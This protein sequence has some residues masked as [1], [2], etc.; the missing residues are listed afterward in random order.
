MTSISGV[1]VSREEVTDL[2]IGIEWNQAIDEWQRI[3][4]W[5]NAISLTTE[6][7]DRH[8]IWG[9]MRR[10]LL[11]TDGTV[12][13]YGSNPRGDGINVYMLDF[14]GGQNEPAIG[15]VVTGAASGDVAT[16][17][18]YEV[19]SGTWGG[20]DATGILYLRSPDAIPVYQDN[21]QLNNTT[22][23]NILANGGAGL[24]A[25]GV[26]Y[27]GPQGYRMMVEIPKFYIKTM[28]PAA[29]IYRWW[30]SPV[31]KPGFVVH[32]AF[33][34]RGGIERDYIF[35][36]A[37]EAD[38]EYNGDDEAYNAGHEELHSR[39]GKQPYTGDAD[40]IW[41]VQFDGGQNEPAIGDDVGTA[42]DDNFFIV[43][44]LV[45]GGAWATNDAVGYLWIRKPG[46][47]A[48]GWVDNEQI[49]NNTQ[50]NIL[51]DAGA[52]LGVNGAPVGRNV[53]IGHARTLASNIGAR[54]GLVNVWSF[55]AIQLLYYVEYANP[56]VQTQIGR[57]IV[58]LPSGTGFYGVETGFGNVDTAIGVNG[59]G[60]GTEEILC[61]DAGTTAF[62][63]GE[64]VTGGTSLV[65]GTIEEVVVRSG[66][67]GGNDAAGYLRIS[68]V[69]GEF[70][71]DEALTSA[72]G[73]ATSDGAGTPSNDAPFVWR[74]IENIGGN[75]W[76]YVDGYNAIDAEYRIIN[77]DGSGTFA[78]ALDRKS[79]V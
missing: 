13:A 34:Q 11:N 7:F 61:F 14:D 62:V 17:V 19:L 53:T 49:D 2:V 70:E 20:N 16:I 45:T 3:N 69:S 54:W 63:A 74:G 66:T 59:T 68:S 41:E 57:G 37:Y 18:D 55:A 6:D 47:A 32:P 44:Y 58:D 35:V 72:S 1:A 56:N 27:G 76:N 38:F 48:C 64:T 77:R 65:T 33:V 39:T 30:I 24:G 40:S 4:E 21:E 25:N 8:P 36:G 12:F 46:N 50:G 42:T 15:D 67:W 28:S 29:N 73:A 22:Q 23:T 75:C 26:I 78:D 31:P 52:G 60:V 51:A 43:D 9:G 10:C 5:G 79:V 71:N